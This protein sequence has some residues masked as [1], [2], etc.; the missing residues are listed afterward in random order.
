MK[1]SSRTYK[2]KGPKPNTILTHARA[3]SGDPYNSPGNTS[4]L[5]LGEEDT[6]LHLLRERLD[7]RTI[8]TFESLLLLKIVRARH[9]RM[10]WEDEQRPIIV[11]KNATARKLLSGNSAKK[12][13]VDGQAKK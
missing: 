4:P 10:E 3:D 6:L 1:N 9:D 7:A 11:K 2:V 5:T 12:G 8:L 13:A